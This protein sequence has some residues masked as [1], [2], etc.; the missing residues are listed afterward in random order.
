MLV[1]DVFTDVRAHG[2]SD[3]IDSTLF[4]FL[5]YC[6]QDVNTR[7]AWPYLE[8]LATGTFVASTSQ[9]FSSITDIKQVLSLIDTTLDYAIEPMR[10]DILFKE[11]PTLLGTNGNPLFYYMPQVNPTAPN[12]WQVNLVPSPAADTYQLRY[13]YIPPVLIATTDTFVLPER[14][15]RLLVLGTLKQCYRL[16]DDKDYA[17]DVEREYELGIQNMREDLWARQYDRPDTIG[18]IMGDNQDAYY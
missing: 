16:E 10:S 1:S 9:Q 13:L 11:Y 17:L 7:E 2:F 8:K 5:N 14:F 3:L 4:G 15:H 12:G 18:D 6:Y